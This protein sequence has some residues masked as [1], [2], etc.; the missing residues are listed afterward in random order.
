MLS[1]KRLSIFLLAASPNFLTAQK[2]I[3][4]YDGPIP[5]AVGYSMKEE[6]LSW[7][8][9]FGGYRNISV[10]TL[11]VYLPDQK[12]SN[13][14]AVVICPGGGYGMESYRL[15]GKNIAA[16][17]ARHGVA[18][19]ILKYRLPSDSIMNDKSIGPV[20][21]AQQAIVI[22]RKNAAKWHIDTAKVGIMGFSAGGHLAS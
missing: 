20:Q 22:V 9:Q 21:D 13:G 5:N 14:S 17:F 7:D 15:E 3:P 11:E 2:V 19:F 16:S 4:L 12:K 1:I 6:T 8:G 18:A 10:P